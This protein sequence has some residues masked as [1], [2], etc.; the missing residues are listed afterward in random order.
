MTTTTKKG[1]GGTVFSISRLQ[2][3][4]FFAPRATYE[5]HVESLSLPPASRPLYAFAEELHAR[6]HRRVLESS[7]GWWSKEKGIRDSGRAHRIPFRRLLCVLSGVATSRRRLRRLENLSGQA[8]FYTYYTLLVHTYIAVGL[9]M[10]VCA[11]I[12]RDR[13]ESSCRR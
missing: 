9:V 10:M 4:S 12:V 2:W 6:V 5:P 1:G 3:R 7:K 11:Y 13:I 8:F